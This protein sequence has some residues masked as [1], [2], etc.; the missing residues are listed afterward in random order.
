LNKFYLCLVA[1][2]VFTGCATQ[3]PRPEVLGLTSVKT[4]HVI[5]LTEP[6]VTVK[7]M[8][9]AFV[10]SYEEGV[11]AGTYAADRENEL[12]TFYVGPSKAYLSRMN[13]ASYTLRR[14][15]FWVSKSEPTAFRFFWVVESDFSLVENI[16]TAQATVDASASETARDIALRANIAS[17]TNLGVAGAAGTGVAS[18]LVGAII[19]S[20]KGEL[21]P[22]AVIE[23]VSAT[24]KLKAR[25]TA[26]RKSSS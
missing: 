2:V 17:P 19:D 21:V 1:C 23:D 4:P 9:S 26:S 20:S 12:G 14:G 24:D 7:K 8:N 13:K 6:V 3:A 11:L 18:A 5:V 16:E 25:L 22:S 10:D 15:G